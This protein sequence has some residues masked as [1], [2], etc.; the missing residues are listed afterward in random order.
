M[1]QDDFGVQLGGIDRPAVDISIKSTA[2]VML[3][4]CGTA[5]TDR[6]R[7]YMYARLASIEIPV[8]ADKSPMV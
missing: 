1:D 8:R 3:S 5:M 7:K 4:R 2:K 6:R